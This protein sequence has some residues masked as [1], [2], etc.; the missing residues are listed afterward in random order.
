MMQHQI[1]VED[2]F[3]F[4]VAEAENEED[5]LTWFLLKVGRGSVLISDL[6][7]VEL[8]SGVSKEAVEEALFSIIRRHCEKPILQERVGLNSEHVKWKRALELPGVVEY[9]FKEVKAIVSKAGSFDNARQQVEQLNHRDI[10]D[11]EISSPVV[12]LEAI[13]I[14]ACREP[15]KHSTLKLLARNIML[16]VQLAWLRLLKFLT[17]KNT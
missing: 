3:K 5:D 6:G 15:G 8:I 14:S 17:S 7:Y 10:I 4:Q 2:A 1:F 9:R 16:R 13:L 11:V 12:M